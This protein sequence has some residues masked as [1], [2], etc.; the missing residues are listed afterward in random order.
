MGTLSGTLQ[1]PEPLERFQ[2]HS[3]AG[4]WERYVTQLSAVSN[5]SKFIRAITASNQAS[6]IAGD[7]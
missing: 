1:R 4:A 6:S 2:L 7:K 5:N 3:N